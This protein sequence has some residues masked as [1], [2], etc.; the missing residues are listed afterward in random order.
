MG[1]SPSPIAG[2]IA[3]C[4]FAIVGRK[5]GQIG[6]PCIDPVG[7]DKLA[8]HDRL[9]IVVCCPGRCAYLKTDRDRFR[10]LG[11][12]YRISVFRQDVF[13]GNGIYR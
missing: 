10:P 1:L 8:G 13:I 11:I 12:D 6:G 2:N 5:V 9:E 3:V 7:D 4:T